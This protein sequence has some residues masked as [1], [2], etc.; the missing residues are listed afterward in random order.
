MLNDRRRMLHE[1]IG[2]ALE[3]TYAESLDDHVAELAHHYAR[4]GNA[5]Q[6]GE[7]LPARGPAMHGPRLECRSGR[8]LRDRAC[9]A[10][11]ASRRRPSRRAGAGSQERSR[12]PA[13]RQQGLRLA[14]KPSSRRRAPWSFA[15]GPASAGERPGRHCSRIFFVQQLRPDVRKAEAIAAEL[16]ARAE[17]RQRRR[18]S[19]GS[20]ELVGVHEDG[21]GQLRARRSSLR[22]GVGAAGIH[23]SESRCSSMPHRSVY[24]PSSCGTRQNNRVLSGW[25]LWFLGYPDRALERMNIATAIAQEPGAPKNILADIH[26]FATYI[27][28]LRREPEQMRT[29][30]E[31]RLALATESGFFTGRALS[32]IYLGWAD[33]M[34]GDAEGGI[35]RMRHHM[36]ELK[37]T[38]SEYISDRYFTFIA[39]ALGRLGRFDEG[40]RVVD[41]SFPF[42]ER[43]G[44]RYYEAELHRL[45]G[46]MLLAQDCIECSASGAILPH[47][48]RNFAQAAC[49]VVGAA[50]DHESRALAGEA[51]P[52][53]RGARR[54]SPKSTTGSPRA[55]TLPI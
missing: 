37:V 36:S 44:Q 14:S 40:L 17:E 19:G 22:P 24:D 23:G 9:A 48:D 4:G 41:E 51:A 29:R 25:N 20:C 11:Q 43:S 31:A 12:R 49:E 3:S 46:E 8:A 2:A 54:C 33:A 53:R 30:A 21:F 38:G 13:G 39:T 15:S 1:R 34:A 16:I 7:I 45:K 27:Y 47:C 32:E 5:A 6:G 42:I 55:S 35:A 10:A 18:I 28:E 52:T 26:G 50:R